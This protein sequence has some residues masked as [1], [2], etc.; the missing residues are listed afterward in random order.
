MV[1][2]F[3]KNCY[4]SFFIKSLDYVF[5]NIYWEQI[6]QVF[7]LKQY[8]LHGELQHALY[9]FLSTCSFAEDRISI[10]QAHQYTFYSSHYLVCR[11]KH[12]HFYTKSHHF[13]AIFVRSCIFL[14]SSFLNNQIG[15]RNRAVFFF[16]LVP[17]YF[18]VHT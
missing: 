10:L 18:F 11:T 13:S 1:I 14:L 6:I 3:V 2:F 5:I 9:T 4:K 17:C 8:S 15:E 7:R 12:L 16:S